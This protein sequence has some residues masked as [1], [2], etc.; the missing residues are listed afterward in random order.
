MKYGALI[1]TDNGYGYAAIIVRGKSKTI[2]AFLEEYNN[3]LS[4]DST[5]F[6]PYA[7]CEVYGLDQIARQLGETRATVRELARDI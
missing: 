4:L 6:I 1:T 2:R 7:F 3:S 5:D